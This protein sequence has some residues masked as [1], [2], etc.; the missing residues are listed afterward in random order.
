MLAV[1]LQRGEEVGVGG[2][3]GGILK[4]L[5]STILLL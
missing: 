5:N 2:G 3:E 1:L 4:V